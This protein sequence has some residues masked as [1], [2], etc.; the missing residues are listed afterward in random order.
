MKTKSLIIV[1]LSISALL[2]S[3]APAAAKL[4]GSQWQ[5]SVMNGKAIPSDVE[6]TLE[7]VNGRAGGKGACN[8]YGADYK[9]SGEK[10]KLGPAVSTMMYCEGVMEIEFEYLKA[11]GEVVSFEIEDSKLFLKNSNGMRM[12][13]FLKK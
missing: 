2:A 7:F 4:D 12:L 8:G 10:L 6:I 1:I 11:F 13:E 5:L 3:C 9:Q